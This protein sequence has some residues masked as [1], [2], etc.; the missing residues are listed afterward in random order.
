MEFIELDEELSVVSLI[1]YDTFLITLAI[2]N[3]LIFLL[4]SKLLGHRPNN[5][6]DT[7]NGSDHNTFLLSSNEPK[8]NEKCILVY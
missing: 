5:D 7:D 6:A 1:N 2:L 4:Y 8:W 3:K